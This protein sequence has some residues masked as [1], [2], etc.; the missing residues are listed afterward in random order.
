LRVESVTKPDFARSFAPFAGDKPGINRSQTSSNFNTGKLSLGVHL[1]TERGRELIKRLIERWQPDIIVESYAPG[2]MKRWGLDYDS[3]RKVRPDI[4]YFA[5]TQLGQT[6]P[7]AHF[8]GFGNLG[9][10]I[11][12]YNEFAGW[13]DRSPIGTH[14]ALPDMVNPSASWFQA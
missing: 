11:A 3:L 14:G 4:I 1:G 2:T 10:A 7:F 12:G 13:P 8:A 6:G 9:G 5:T